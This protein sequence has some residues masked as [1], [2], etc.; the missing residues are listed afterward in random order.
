M[1]KLDDDAWDSWKLCKHEAYH[2][3]RFSS[4][5]YSGDDG[6]DGNDG[7]DDYWYHYDDYSQYEDD[8]DPW[9]LIDKGQ[10]DKYTDDKVD[11]SQGWNPEG[12]DDN[13]FGGRSGAKLYSYRQVAGEDELLFE[14][15]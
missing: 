5:Y 2:T 14:T 13:R 7:D 12:T 15:R 11:V 3:F 9:K 10:V 8:E 4:R 1:S 6:D